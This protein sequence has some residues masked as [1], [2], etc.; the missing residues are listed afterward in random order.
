MD[1]RHQEPRRARCVESD[2]LSHVMGM[3]KTMDQRE[4]TVLRMRFGLDDHEP[5]TLKEIGEAARPDPRARSPDRDRGP[6]QAARRAAGLRWRLKWR[7]E[8]PALPGMQECGR[9]QEHGV[10]GAQRNAAPAELLRD[11]AE[12][13]VVSLDG[14]LFGASPG[15]W[16]RSDPGTPHGVPRLISPSTASSVLAA[17]SDSLAAPARKSFD[18]AGN[19][20]ID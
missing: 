7:A 3:L 1:E 11:W 12:F 17:Q 15:A 18:R 2:N 10:A 16:L 6:G 20:S 14:T 9:L 5:R 8:F 19:G 4:A 13:V